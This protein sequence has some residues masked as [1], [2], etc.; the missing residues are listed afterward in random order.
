MDPVVALAQLGGTASLAQLVQM[1]SRGRV[2]AAAERGDVVR[3]RRGFYALSGLSA[4]VALRCGGVLAGPSAAQW[5]GLALKR[6][7]PRPVVLVPRGA[8]RPTEDVEVRWGPLPVH[9]EGVTD[10]WRTVADCARWLA[11]DDALVVVDSALRS[12]LRAGDLAA[13]AAALPRN[14]RSR[15]GAVVA[16]GDPGAASALES[17]VRAHARQVPG[18]ALETQVQIGPHRVDLADR[19]RR[20]A[21][22]CDSFGFH[23]GPMAYARDVRRYTELV[24]EGWTVLR[25]SWQEAMD[26]AGWVVEALSRAT[27]SDTRPFRHRR[28]A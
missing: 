3:V 18:L 28:S 8:S 20:V 24:V 27:G 16:A 17:L 12:G 13:A 6:P 23:G 15:A 7:P 19:R 5:H 9:R 14:G 4:E 1:T 22:E 21:V 10:R 2:R 26:E 25:F 11:F